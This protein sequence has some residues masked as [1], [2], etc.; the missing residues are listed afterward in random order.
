[1]LNI[2]YLSQQMLKLLPSFKKHSPVNPP[3]PQEQKKLKNIR[4][5]KAKYKF[6]DF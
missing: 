1:M 5:D 3:L 4:R 6:F 2:K